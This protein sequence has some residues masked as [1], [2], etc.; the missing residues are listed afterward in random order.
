LFFRQTSK[1]CTGSWSSATRTRS[2]AS[3]AGRP[4]LTWRLSTC[5]AGQCCC[6]LCLFIRVACWFR[7]GNPVCSGG[8]WHVKCW[9]ILSTG[10]VRKKETRFLPSS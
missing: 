6:L 1:R 8:P 2:S 9:Y 4:S 10:C 7:V 3:F 5:R